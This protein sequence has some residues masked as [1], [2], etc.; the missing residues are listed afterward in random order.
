MPFPWQLLIKS[1]EKV[2]KYL[3]KEVESSIASCHVGQ[4]QAPFL[5]TIL[6]KLM[7]MEE[8]Q[9]C[10]GEFVTWTLVPSERS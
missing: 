6:W 8:L 10:F 4:H 2:A 3:G 5:M 1:W 7:D 9:I